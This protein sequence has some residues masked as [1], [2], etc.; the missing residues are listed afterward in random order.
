MMDKIRKKYYSLVKKFHQLENDISDNAIH[1]KR[2]ILCKVRAVLLVLDTKEK[3]IHNGNKV[4]ALMGKMRNL[5]V[6]RLILLSDERKSET[7]PYILYLEIKLKKNGMKIRKFIR[8]HQ[9]RFPEIDRTKK[10]DAEQIKSEL[11]L[12]HD[13]LRK[14]IVAID[15]YEAAT[16]HKIRKSFKRFRYLI[17]ILSIVKTVDKETLDKLKEFQDR[18]GEIQDFRMLIKGLNQFSLK[19][20][21][22]IDILPFERIQSKLISKFSEEID[23]FAAFCEHTTLVAVE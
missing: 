23:C 7:Y 10:T 17:E 8:K 5:Q 18:L 14:M 3:H 1:D 6:Q 21:S 4:F 15:T 9:V 16:I 2:V 13:K 19:I 11:L 12:A 20:N 22:P